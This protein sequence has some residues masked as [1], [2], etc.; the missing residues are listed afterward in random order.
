VAGNDD[1][2]DTE[3]S[4][5]YQDTKVAADAALNGG[6]IGAARQ[7]IA[8]LGKDARALDAAR[9]SPSFAAEVAAR[10]RELAS[11]AG[12][13]YWESG[14]HHAG[15]AY[16]TTLLAAEPGLPWVLAARGITYRLMGRHKDAITDLSA[17]IN[18]DPGYAL[19]LANRGEV[20]RLEGEYTAALADLK[21]AVSLLP[22]YAWAIG[23]R[24]QVYQELGRTSEAL[25]DFEHALGL[26]RDLR[27][28]T[29]A[30]SAMA[31][32]NSAC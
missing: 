23:S 27:W 1:A 20:W 4:S 32:R 31:A 22:D 19:A 11:S 29:A 13:A 8:D 21:A 15:V 3:R 17:A 5:R 9:H 26:D 6:D 30:K 24:G 12:R 28:V 2:A 7:L 10:R 18:A 25:A 16:F 14:R